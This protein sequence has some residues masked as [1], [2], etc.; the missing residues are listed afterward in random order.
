MIDQKHIDYSIELSHIYT[1]ERY[2]EEHRSSVAL[3]KKHE[4]AFGKGE[5]QSCVM[6]DN[7][8]PTEHLLDVENFFAELK[9]DGIVPNYF[10][11]E[12]DMIRHRDRL[13]GD[14][15]D[16]RIYKS[17]RSYA[18]KKDKMPCSFMTAIWYLVR[19]GIYDPEGIIMDL[20]GSEFIPAKQLVSILPERFRSVEMQTQ[21]LLQS[22]KGQDLAGKVD[23][24]FY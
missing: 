3:L 1:N 21:K 14:I 24:Y 8:N 16:N 4:A 12:A 10:A 9:K 15:G 5:T 22:I 20:E 18:E 2:S 6:I 17:Y 19:L 11:F 23:Y 7:Y 13:L